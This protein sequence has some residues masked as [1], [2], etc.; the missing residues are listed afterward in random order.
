MYEMVCGEPPFYSDDIPTMY[1]NI[2]E[3]TLKFSSKV[4][5]EAKNCIKRLLERD[6]NKRLGA[7][8]KQEIKDDPFFNGVDWN[9]VLRKEYRPPITD[10]TDLQ[11][12][13]IDDDYDIGYK[14]KVIFFFKQNKAHLQ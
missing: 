3:G 5:E 1:K 11:D 4:S 8:N 2:K 6:P 12:D 14:G 9:K 13:D 10:F 7:K